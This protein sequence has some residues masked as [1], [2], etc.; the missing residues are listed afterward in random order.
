MFVCSLRL[1][2]V[3]SMNDVYYPVVCFT[4]SVRLFDRLGS[5]ELMDLSAMSQRAT[6]IQWM[7]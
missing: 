1:A 4:K 5:T 3:C 6:M 2:N 7:G